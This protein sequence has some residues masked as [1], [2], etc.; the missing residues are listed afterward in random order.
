M[1]EVV[2]WYLAMCLVI[3]VVAYREDRLLKKI[4]QGYNPNA[5]DGDKDGLVQEGTRWERKV[6]K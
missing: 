3:G 6:K 4:S 2:L 5:R 1:K